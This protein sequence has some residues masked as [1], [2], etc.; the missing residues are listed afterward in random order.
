MLFSFFFLFGVFD[1]LGFG[2]LGAFPLCL[3]V[4]VFWGFCFEEDVVAGAACWLEVV[5]SVSSELSHKKGICSFSVQIFGLFSLCI[6]RGR[7]E[8]AA[9]SSSDV[10]C[11]F[12]YKILGDA[13]FKNLLMFLRIFLKEKSLHELCCNSF[14]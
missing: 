4:C 9:A 14:L 7:V 8:K 6:K 11:F 3:C 12:V 2:E 1:G 10:L 13:D 5:V